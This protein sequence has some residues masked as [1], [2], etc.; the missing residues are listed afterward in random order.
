MHKSKPI[1]WLCRHEDHKHCQWK[2]CVCD[3]H[4][5]LTRQSQFAAEV[6]QFWCQTCTQ[7]LRHTNVE[8]HRQLNHQVINL[9]EDDHEPTN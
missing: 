8:L 3:H 9:N 4:V 5:R 7:R 6:S 2:P 1:S